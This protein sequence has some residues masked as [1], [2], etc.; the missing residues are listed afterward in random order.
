LSKVA[1][2]PGACQLELADSIPRLSGPAGQAL[3]LQAA[4]ALMLAWLAVEGPTPRERLAGLLWP[5][6]DATSA[7][8]ALRQRLFRLRRMGGHPLVT[9]STVLELHPGARHDLEG[10]A[11]LLGTLQLRLG[12][13]V[14]AWLDAQRARR[15]AGIRRSLEARIDALEASGDFAHALPLALTLLQAHPHSEDAHRRVIRLH[16][17]RG[18]RAAALLAFDR[19]EHVLKHEV[20]ASPALE[21]LELLAT[22]EQPDV[23]DRTPARL[24]RVPLVLYRPP[25]MV[26]RDSEI[27]ALRR[28]WRAGSHTL[29]LALPGLGRT[30]LLDWLALHEMGL[31]RASLL[32]DATAWPLAAAR[33][34]VQSVLRGTATRIEPDLIHRL[35]PLLEPPPGTPPQA[36]AERASAWAEPVA[37]LLEAAGIEVLAV[38]D[39]QRA[40]PASLALFE[41]LA[42]LAPVRWCFSMR[43]SAPG[44]IPHSFAARLLAAGRSTEVFLGRLDETSLEALL[45]SLGLDDLAGLEGQDG[46]PARSGRLGRSAAKTL[47]SLTGGHPQFVLEALRIAWREAGS[48]P[49]GQRWPEPTS[50]AARA[51]AQLGCLSPPALELA[52][53]AALAGESFS[54]KLAAEVLNRHPLALADA[55]AE[56]ERAQ[57]LVQGQPASQIVLEALRAG[58][59]QPLAAELRARIAAAQA[60]C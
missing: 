13:E 11:T 2:P 9:G 54:V 28:A 12:R 24:G 18:D 39:V 52:R 23:V 26:G 57:L 3:I 58:V 47:L 22:V 56:A 25:L 31:C 40:D 16:Y 49:D 19:C 32:A 48:G 20:G 37:A 55:W 4:D 53:L 27:T 51:A 60:R 42:E 8:N 38:D 6:K 29:L 1:E 14:D 34:V 45:D 50:F 33:R 43:L 35:H 7:R 5:D 41:M 30:R 46:T 17:L 15:Q 21:T 10:A 36:G 44:S 59:P